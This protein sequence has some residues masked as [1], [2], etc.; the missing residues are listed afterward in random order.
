MKRILLLLFAVF[1]AGALGFAIDPEG[2]K[3]NEAKQTQQV[4]DAEIAFAAAA[5]AK[6]YEKAMSFWDEDIHFFNDGKMSSGMAAQRKNWEFLK[7]PNVSITWSPEIVEASGGLGYT[8]GPYELRVKQKDGSEKVSH[9]RYTT[10]WRRKPNGAWK[11]A[12][13]VGSP[14][15]PPAKQ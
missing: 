5:R 13:D 6:D 10:I 9:G 7:D 1:L 4:R 11:A 15:P 14:E 8:T 2:K 3:A 12:L